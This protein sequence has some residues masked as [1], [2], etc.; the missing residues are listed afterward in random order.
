MRQCFDDVIATLTELASSAG[1]EADTA[2]SRKDQEEAAV[3]TALE[4]LKKAIDD[5]GSHSD[6]E[7][8]RKRVD[9]AR[10]RVEVVHE[11][12]QEARAQL[13]AAQSSVRSVKEMMAVVRALRG[14]KARDDCDLLR[15]ALHGLAERDLPAAERLLGHL[16][17]RDSW[18]EMRSASD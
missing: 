14:T 5:L 13:H 16:V 7:Q 9:D 17:E 10:A 6:L 1:A 11:S 18:W 8:A 3:T 12:L 2:L 15:E 4:D